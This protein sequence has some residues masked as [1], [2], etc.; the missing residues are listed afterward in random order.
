IRD[1]NVTGVQTCALPIC[2]LLVDGGGHVVEVGAW[3]GKGGT[4]QLTEAVEVPGADVLDLG[5]DVD[6]EVE[7]VGNS[8][9]TGRRGLQD[10]DALDDEDVG[11]MDLLELPRDGVVVQVGVDGDVDTFDT[12]LHLRD[13][14]DQSATVV[15]FRETLATHEAPGLEDGVGVEEV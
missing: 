15:A 4:S 2:L 14:T 5:V 1:R 6:G 9:V 10:V 3:V 7:E 8:H 12:G 11:A 13:E